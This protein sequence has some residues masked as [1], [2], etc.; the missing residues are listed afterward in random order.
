M[1]DLDARAR[2]GRSYWESTVRASLITDD[3]LVT[4]V[5]ERFRLA[6]AARLSVSSQ[7]RERIPEELA[8]KHQ[9]L[10]LTLSDSG[11]EIATA[12]PT[13]I[14]CERALGFVAGCHIRIAIASPFRI[15]ARIEEVYRPEDATRR[16]LAGVGEHYQIDA[17]LDEPGNGDGFSLDGDR[18]GPIIQV[19]DHIITNATSARASDIHLEPGERD[20]V[21]RY[22]VDGVLRDVM[23]IPRAIAIPLVSRIKIMAQLDI[24]DRLRPQGGHAALGVDGARMD[25]RVSTLPATHGE[26]VVIRILDQRETA[27]S[28]D[29]LGFAGETASRIRGLLDARDGI[30]LVTGPTGSGKTTTLYAMLRQLQKRGVNIVTVEDPVEYRISGI[31]QVQVNEKAGLT[32]ASA[33]RS[34]LRQDPDIVLIG[35][36]RDRET[37]EIAIQASLTGHLVFAT[38]HTIDASTSVMRLLDLGVERE[39]VATALRGVLAQRLL[40]RV[41]AYCDHGRLRAG[42]ACPRCGGGGYSGRLAIAEVIVATPS[43]ER[44]IMEGSGPDAIVDAAR[45]DG[46]QSLWEAG[47]RHVAA[48]ATTEDELRRV[49]EQR[50]EAGSQR[51]GAG[52]RPHDARAEARLYDSVMDGRKGSAGPEIVAGVVDVHVLRR[53]NG[54]WRVL[55]LRRALDTRC[56]GAWEAVHGR[57]EA[58]ER[59]EDAAI[60][61]VTEE[62]G[63]VVER[64]YNATVQPFYLHMFG[65]VQL[66]IAF[67]AVVSL[68]EVRLGSEHQSHEWLSVDG[69]LE[70]LIWPRSREA[71][72]II[73]SLLATGDAGPVEDVL[74]V[75]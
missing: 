24:A 61:E 40:R 1:R 11:L 68:D 29:S 31:V 23:T 18:V 6:R 20:T 8:R 70:R 16:L 57:I 2:E 49:V 64:L 3:E 33:L 75:R 26:K 67:A 25:L 5:A 27:R 44:A 51:S 7:A 55:V 34:I 10:P 71:L 60:R 63:L 35:E 13:D 15:A 14:D 21:V 30:I 54:E 4:L 38:L 46:A 22:R 72:R 9:I 39:K 41:C 45:R 66:A 42:A 74:R 73:A 59:P 56:P 12:D 19:V 58:G 36:V 52:N 43:L 48:G 32:F 47:Q 28:L 17:L 53:E 50:E 37:A 62:T 65:A 69:A